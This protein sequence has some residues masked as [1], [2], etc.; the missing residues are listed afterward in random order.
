MCVAILLAFC[1]VLFGVGMGEASKMNLFLWVHNSQQRDEKS[2]FCRTLWTRI[3][4]LRWCLSHSS[5]VIK[6]EVERVIF[7][8]AQTSLA[9][10]QSR[11]VCMDDSTWR[12]HRGQRGEGIMFLHWRSWF[13]GRR[14]HHANQRKNFIFG[15]Q[16][17]FHNQSRLCWGF[18]LDV[19]A[20]YAKTRENL[21]LA[22]KE[23]IG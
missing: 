10:L 1:S 7:A 17:P 6:G 21:L 18:R 2:K 3:E 4:E 22:S 11:S 23:E 16:V 19:R 9:T 14:F 5:L 20:E 12:E 13:V 15:V 8:R